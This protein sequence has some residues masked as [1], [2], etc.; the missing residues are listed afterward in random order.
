MFGLSRRA[1][2]LSVAEAVR[3][4]ADGTMTLLD[5]RNADEVA[6][7]GKAAGAVHVPLTLLPM[8]ADPRSPDFDARLAPDHPVAVYCASGARSGQAVQVL[9]RLGFAEAHN[10]GGFGDWVRAG[11][12]TE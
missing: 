6:R 4:V 8:R 7:S 3:R 9:Q 12:A 5:V 2:G 10:I 11:G 1:K